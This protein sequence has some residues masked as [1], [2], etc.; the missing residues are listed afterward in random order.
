MIHIIPT[1]QMRKLKY[2]RSR[3]LTHSHQQQENARDLSSGSMFLESPLTVTTFSAC[4]WAVH[5]NST[6]HMP[7]PCLW[8]SSGNPNYLSL[9]KLHP[10]SVQTDQVDEGCPFKSHFFFKASAPAWASPHTPAPDW[11]SRVWRMSWHFA[12]GTFLVSSASFRPLKNKAHLLKVPQIR[13]LIL[14]L[15]SCWALKTQK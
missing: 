11:V 12:L 3:Y 9:R 8:L 10:S 1:W 5:Q 14:Y 13:F 15:A 7:G 6:W 2:K 4:S